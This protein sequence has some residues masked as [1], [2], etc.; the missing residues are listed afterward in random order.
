MTGQTFLDIVFSTQQ[1]RW[2]TT[3]PS[4]LSPEAHNSSKA[5]GLDVRATL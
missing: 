4:V 1:P 5:V 2:L 3:S